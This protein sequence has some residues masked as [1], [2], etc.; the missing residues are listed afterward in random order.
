MRFRPFALFLACS[1]ALPGLLAADTVLNF[2][3]LGDGVS[4]TTQFSGLTFSNTIALTA[5]ISLDE[6]EFPPHSG[7]VVVSD[8]G[9]PIGITFAAPV[10]TF[11]GYFTYAEP[12][13]LTA[14]DASST[15]VDSATSAFSN[16]MGL[17]GDPGSSPNELLSLSFA[18]GISSVLLEGDS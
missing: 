4:V 1:L 6:F 8:D 15:A 18:G 11:G 7:S 12:L 14:F 9:G 17:S 2:E 5:G 3:S 10:T 13:T 16:N